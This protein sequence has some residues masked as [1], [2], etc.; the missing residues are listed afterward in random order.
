MHVV[1]VAYKRDVNDMRES[2][3]L[4]V[5]ELLA[6]RGAVHQ[7]HAIRG[8]RISGTETQTLKSIELEQGHRRPA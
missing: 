6:K 8:C 5:I 2:P 7:L 4:D 3:A 1:G